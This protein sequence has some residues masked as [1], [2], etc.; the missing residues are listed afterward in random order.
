M[1]KV[2]E[3]QHGYLCEIVN[4]SHCERI[5]PWKTQHQIAGGKEDIKRSLAGVLIKISIG[6]QSSDVS[7]F[8]TSSTFHQNQNL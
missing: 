5:R 8:S 6:L 7:A 3:I 2:A 4:R 1:R